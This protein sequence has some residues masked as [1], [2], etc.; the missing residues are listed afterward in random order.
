M[1][2]TLGQL[3]AMNLARP[4]RILIRIALWVTGAGYL[5]IEAR[6]V[7]ATK[8]IANIT[9]FALLFVLASHQLNISKVYLLVEKLSLATRCYRA[10]SLMFIASLM[11]VFDASI[12][13]L[14]SSV[15]P[16]SLSSS[17]LISL[18]NLGWVVNLVAVILTLVSMELFLPVM[19]S[20]PKT[21]PDDWAS[22]T[23]SNS[24]K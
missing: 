5:F 19:V 3:I 13:F 15:S 12:D 14:I 24:R 17:I 4:S 21:T 6:E 10:S 22:D 7:V 16:E 8:Q 18:F 20:G 23:V 1:A 11:A 9:I 2:S